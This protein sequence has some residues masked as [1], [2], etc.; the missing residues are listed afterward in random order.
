MCLQV[1]DWI[2]PLYPD[3]P[4]LLSNKGVFTFP[5]T[6]AAVPGS[7]VGVVLSSELP[8]ADRDLFQEQ[9]S[10]LAQLRVQVIN[11][12]FDFKK[13]SYDERTLKL[14]VLLNSNSCFYMHLILYKL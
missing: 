7:Y 3:S 1:C 13:K 14:I 4:V 8:A 2:Y 5:D 9:L 10:V 11:L 12:T 6:T